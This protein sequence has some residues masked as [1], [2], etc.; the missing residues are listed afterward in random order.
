MKVRSLKGAA[1]GQGYQG[2]EGGYPMGPSGRRNYG[3]NYRGGD[4]SGR[5]VNQG[6]SMQIDE[7]QFP[8]ADVNVEAKNE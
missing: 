8:Q 2:E 4:Y 5:G 6:P 3:G 7:T 1:M